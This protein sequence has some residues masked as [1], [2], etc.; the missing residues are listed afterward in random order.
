[1]RIS[2]KTVKRDAMSTHEAQL[3]RTTICLTQLQSCQISV[4]SL[5]VKEL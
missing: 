5:T 1:M 3:K 4:N 2:S